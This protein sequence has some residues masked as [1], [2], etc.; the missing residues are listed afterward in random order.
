[1]VRNSKEDEKAK[2][3]VKL[4]RENVRQSCHVCFF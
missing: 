3:N 1:M 4:L 2:A